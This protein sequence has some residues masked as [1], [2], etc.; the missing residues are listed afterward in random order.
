MGHLESSSADA[1]S[2]PPGNAACACAG[3]VT[4]WTSLWVLAATPGLWLTHPWTAVSP[5]FT[6]FLLLYLS[7]EPG[8]SLWGAGSRVQDAS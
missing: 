1:H 5:A 4:L 2:L 8:V 7:G 6:S 3:E